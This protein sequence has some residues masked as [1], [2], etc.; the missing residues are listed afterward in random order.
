[1]ALRYIDAHQE[2][3]SFLFVSFIEPHHQNQRADYPA[4]EGYWERYAGRWIPPD[5][6][7]L[8]GSTHQ[9]LAGYFG[10]VKRL[11]E[12]LGRLLDALKSLELQDDTV[13]LF[14]SDHGCHFKTRNSE[15]KRSCHDSSIRVPTALQG[16]G[17][18]G[19]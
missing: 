1:A 16:P 10:M 3:P 2:R 12:G 8:G 9:H 4:P 17:F 15:Y 11:D 13:L 19:G 18:E 14:T 7:S 5:L 6:A